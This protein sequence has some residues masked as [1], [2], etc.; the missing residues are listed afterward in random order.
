MNYFDRHDAD[1]TLPNEDREILGGATFDCYAITVHEGMGGGAYVSESF[2]T[3]NTFMYR[4]KLYYFLTNFSGQISGFSSS[5]WKK[6]V[7]ADGILKLNQ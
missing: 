2:P 1:I 6:R 3:S 4:G 5:I 7:V